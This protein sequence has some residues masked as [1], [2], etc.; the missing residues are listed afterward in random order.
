MSLESALEHTL[1]QVPGCQAAACVD[2]ASATV[3]ATRLRTD[4]PPQVLDLLGPVTND[5]F[6]SVYVDLVAQAFGGACF[7]EIALHSA[8][9]SLLLMR[10]ADT[11][12][13]VL[14]M[15][16]DRHVDVQR[17][18]DQARSSLDLLEAAA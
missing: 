11:P 15:V 6:E 1:A 2:Q 14:L 13:Q 4:V 3:L 16:C 7:D 18:L 9:V 12:G 17:T 10:H 5:L 8:K